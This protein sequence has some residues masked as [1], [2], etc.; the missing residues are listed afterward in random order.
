MLD[1]LNRL[2]H[3]Q[4]ALIIVIL[5]FATY[6]DSLKNQFLGDDSP[7][8]VYNPIVQSITNIKM[9]FEG[10]TFY[11]GPGEKLSG[12]YFRPL[13]TTTF[14][15]LYTLF[16]PHPFYF[17]LLQLLIC[18]ASAII[19]YLFYRYSF[20][21]ALALPLALIFLI[22][23]ANSQVVFEIAAMQDALFFFFGI[24]ALYLLARFKSNRSLIAVA[25]YLL[26]SFF[27]KETGVV[28]LAMAALY[29]FW[30]NRKR[31]YPFLAIMVIPLAVYLLLRVHAVGLVGAN[32]GNTP[33]DN[34]GLAGRLFTVPSILLFYFTKIFFPLRLAH[35][36]YWTYPTFSY[37]YFLLPL[38][39]DCAVIGLVVYTGRVLRRVTTGALYHCY[40]YFSVW[41]ALGLLLCV[42]IIPLDMTASESWLYFP[43][44]GALGMIGVVIRVF[45]SRLHMSRQL[46]FCLTAALIL[47][48]AIRTIDR[49][50]NWRNINTLAFNDAKV[51]NDD[52]YSDMVVAIDLFNRG[53]IRGAQAQEEH[54]VSVYPNGTNEQALGTIDSRLGEYPRSLQAYANGLKYNNTPQLDQELYNSA[55]ELSIWYANPSSSVQFINQGLEKFPHDANLWLYLAIIQYQHQDINDAK[56]S[57]Q[58]ALHYNRTVLIATVYSRISKNQPL[59]I[60]KP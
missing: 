29:L 12:T 8:I 33:I 23:P 43:M 60:E 44:A 27:S 45:G 4:A 3:K 28:F 20:K 36:Y 17:H 14:S 38:I 41:F 19:L 46:V 24:L 13:M 2:T 22:H 47:I 9:F 31:L 25:A 11:N 42:Q 50:T 40:V 53:D 56:V 37:M 32:P 35:A 51:S 59:Q 5:G 16:G 18:I 1:K 55:G 30:Y 34:V 26:L 21:P 39:I 6:F 57:I 54:S 10:G 7:Q 52:F 48:F 58:Q 49:G 15:A